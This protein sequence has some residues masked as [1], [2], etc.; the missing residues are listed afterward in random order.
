MNILLIYLAPIND[1]ASSTK[2]TLGL[3]YGLSKLGH[4][5]DVLTQR[6]NNNEIVKF[7]NT[8]FIFINGG[9]SYTN[10][11]VGKEKKNIS[12]ILFLSKLYRL[13]FIHGHA[14]KYLRYVKIGILPSFQYDCIISVSDPKLS[15]LALR[16]LV[17]NG[18]GFKKIIEYWGDPL[19]GDI[20]FKSIYPKFIL[21]R[22]EKNLLFQS[23]KIIYTSP[24]TVEE[25][26]KLFPGYAS[27]MSYVPSA[28]S[29]IMNSASS[30]ENG[31]IV[32]YYGSY[33]STERNILPL[34]NASK[35]FKNLSFN[36]VGNSDIKLETTEN[37][38]VLP[39]GETSSFEDKTDIFVC[40]L[41]KKGTQIPGKIYYLGATNKPVLIIVDGDKKEKMIGYFDSFHRYDICDN[42]EEDIV[43]AIKDILVRDNKVIP[44]EQLKPETIA[45]RFLK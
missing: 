25:Q 11:G 7:S 1:T 40:I 26:A 43:K 5:L 9:D 17:K 15:H 27:K 45:S 3:I 24:F 4:H 30:N 35:H 44:C 22:I 2:R 39:R 29:S 13:F 41:N 38:C 21:R 12:F 20:T 42:T 19:C 33:F 28:C 10:T 36:I 6:I 18:L 34:Y 14:K 8:N 31:L 23:D 37:I 32:G 16:K